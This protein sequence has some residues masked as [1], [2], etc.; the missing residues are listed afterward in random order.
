M[1]DCPFLHGAATS[2]RAGRTPRDWWPAR[3]DLA[4]LRQHQPTGDPMGASFDYAAAFAKLDYSALKADLAALMTASKEWWPADYGHYGPLF[5]RMAWHSSGTYRAGDGRGGG[6]HGNQRFAP[7]NSWPDNANLDK[8]RRLLWPIKRK[9][10]NGISW[11]DLLLL[12]GN[13]AMESMGGPVLGFGGGRTDIYA[14]EV[15]VYWGKEAEWLGD[16]RHGNGGA[17]ESLE[18]PLA[19]TLMGLIYVDPEGPGGN[20]DPLLSAQD[21]RETFRRMRMNDEETVALIAGGHTFGKCHGAGDAALV[22]PEPEGAPIEEVGLGWKSAHASGKGRDTITSGIEGAWTPSPTQWDGSYFDM[23]LGYK[24]ELSKSPAGAH[25]WVPIGATPDHMAPD[26]GDASLPRVSCIMTTADMALA[27]DPAYA[28]ISRRFRD[29][30]AAFSDAFA[31]AWF[32]LLHKDMGPKVRYL[33]PEV[34]EEDFLWQDNV[35]TGNANFDVEE[36]KF[37]LRASVDAGKLSVAEMVETA[38]ASA[39]TFRTSDLRG[40]SNGARIRLEPQRSWEANK[41]VQLARVLGVLTPL[42]EKHS[43]SVA[44]TIVLAGVVAVEVALA[45]STDPGVRAV[46]V[47]FCC[48]RG[49]ASQEQT[50]VDSFRVLEPHADG[51]RNFL[52]PGLGV[53]PEEL[54]VDRAQLLGLTVPEMAVLVSGLRS[55]G[56][57]SAD[58]KGIFQG[59]DGALSNEWFATLLDTTEWRKVGEDTFESDDGL[60]ASRCDLIFASH[61][62]LRAVA[63]VYAQ[64][65]NRAHFASDFVKAFCKVMENGL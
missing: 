4:L 25:Q 45:A 40:G 23:L 51:F 9:Y 5:V 12:A 65:D 22:G 44:D 15:D 39:C 27:Q 52:K 49:D 17:H 24:W 7:L 41:P 21:I 3:L 50:S 35:P 61:S 6:N 20:P 11:A 28:A 1:A 2:A 42:A 53:P 14:P 34:P 56:V 64:D 60:T 10:G 19:A 38:W 31:K 13:V 37:D 16:K 48:G 29:D 58:G 62:E 26:A 36:L 30:H 8:A 63:E 33:G 54:M 46:T 43:A 55:L 32:K 47:P 18:N 57:S 59:G